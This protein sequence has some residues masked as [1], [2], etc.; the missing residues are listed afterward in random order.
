MIG[1]V[2]RFNFS[3]FCI[4]IKFYYPYGGEKVQFTKDELAEIK[5]S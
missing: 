2:A 3:Q 4:Q 5:V 1:S